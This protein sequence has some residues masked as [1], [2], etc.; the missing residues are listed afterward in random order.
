VRAL[1]RCQRPP[2]ERIGNR[3]RLPAVARARPL[4][5]EVPPVRERQ[6]DRLG[7]ELPQAIQD[8]QIVERKSFLAR[9]WCSAFAA[10][11]AVGRS[12]KE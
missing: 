8:V 9:C 1:E 4:D 10:A 3:V 5:T 2:T 7:V 11:A 12:R 6:P